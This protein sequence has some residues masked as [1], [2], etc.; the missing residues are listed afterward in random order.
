MYDV[1][2]INL[3]GYNFI[4]YSD[5]L[6]DACL[7]CDICQNNK[8]IKLLMTLLLIRECKFIEYQKLISNELPDSG[9]K[10][11]VALYLNSQIFADLSE[12]NNRQDDSNLEF[13][14]ISKMENIIRKLLVK[15]EWENK[16]QKLRK[17][18]DA[19]EKTKD[20]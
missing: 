3:A 20:K 5:K 6:G 8:N 16:N 7:I 4:Q 9:T 1:Q 14:K 12:K 19:I 17:L 15:E 18:L 11:I 10:E 2:K 13:I